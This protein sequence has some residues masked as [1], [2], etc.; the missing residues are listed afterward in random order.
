MDT[1]HKSQESKDKNQSVERNNIKIINNNSIN[2]YLSPKILIKDMK[3]TSMSKNINTK[4]TLI[5]P[6]I[7]NNTLELK[8]RESIS[9]Y[10]K[11]AMKKM[12]IS[13][14]KTKSKIRTAFI[15][16]EEEETLKRK[17]F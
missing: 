8:N 11:L 16:N 1:F 7:P 6:K 4:N 3:N 13:L 9:K 12:R 2:S 14:N 17:K 5:L 15:N 10:S